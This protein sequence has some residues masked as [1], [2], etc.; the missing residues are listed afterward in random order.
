MP[1]SSC[2]PMDRR[3][4]LRAGAGAVAGACVIVA[5]GCDDPKATQVDTPAIEGGSRKKLD[6][7]KSKAPAAG[8]AKGK[9]P[10]AAPAKTP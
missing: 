5:T 10:A 6:L 7:L 1:N 3:S 9:V 4:F 2:S 8:T